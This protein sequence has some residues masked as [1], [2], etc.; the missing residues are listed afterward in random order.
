MV[1]G[2]RFQQVGSDPEDVGCLVVGQDG[3]PDVLAGEPGVDGAVAG[4]VA[5]VKAGATI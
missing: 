5:G 2:S 1:S 3:E 4:V